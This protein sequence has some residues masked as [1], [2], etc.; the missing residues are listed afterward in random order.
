MCLCDVHIIDGSLPVPLPQLTLGHEA[1]G[2][3]AA[4]GSHVA[5][6]S[7]GDRVVIVGGRSCGRCRSCVGGHPPDRCPAYEIMG[8]HYDGAW[9]D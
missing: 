5:R 9:A 4:L 6:W 1:S 8:A 2:V 3:I 7:E